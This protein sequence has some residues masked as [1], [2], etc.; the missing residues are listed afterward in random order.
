MK[1]HVP[2]VMVPRQ[3]FEPECDGYSNDVK[4]LFSVVLSYASSPEEM[5]EIARMIIS[6]DHE[7]LAA[8]TAEAEEKLKGEKRHV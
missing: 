2:Y 8:L 1:S 5:R 6:M 7:T 4:L 3:L